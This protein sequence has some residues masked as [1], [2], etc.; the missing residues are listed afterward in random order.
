[1]WAGNWTRMHAPI[2]EA[3]TGRQKVANTA[4]ETAASR[5]THEQQG[6]F[7]KGVAQLAGLP[8]FLGSKRRGDR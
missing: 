3:E 8:S 7:A 4:L 1:M 5:F 6:G 2:G